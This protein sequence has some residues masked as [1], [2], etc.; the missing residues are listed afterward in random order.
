MKT[1][2]ALMLVAIIGAGTWSL[3]SISQVD[4]YAVVES[5]YEK[6]C[7]EMMKDFV[8]S[9]ETFKVLKTDI[10]SGSLSQEDAEQLNQE[11]YGEVE[12]AFELGQENIAERYSQPRNPLKQTFIKV[13]FSSANSYGT[14]MRNDSLCEFV[15][16]PAFQ[17]P[18]LAYFEVDGEGF[19]K[20]S[21]EFTTLTLLKVDSETLE[22]VESSTKG[23]ETEY[24]S[25]NLKATF[26][27]KAGFWINDN[28]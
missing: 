7:I 22:M 21:T 14:P 18:V 2:L 5:F 3:Y 8:K 13:R 9:P 28:L 1:I 10:L 26:I 6:A 25:G 19:S 4:D 24:P 17:R 15:Q 11:Y 12:S 23:F 20:G 16:S 27:Q